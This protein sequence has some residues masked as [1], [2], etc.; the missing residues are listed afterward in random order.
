MLQIMIKSRIVLLALPF[1]LATGCHS[2]MRH[3]SQTPAPTSSSPAVRVYPEESSVTK[4]A[5]GSVSTTEMDDMDVAVRLRNDIQA[6]PAL[7]SAAKLVDIEI[8]NRHAILRGNVANEK[9]RNLLTQKM[10]TFPGV[11]SMDDRLTVGHP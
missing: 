1:V 6:D 10:S 4:A 3:G 2:H 9:D 11:T 7:R 8:I 5:P